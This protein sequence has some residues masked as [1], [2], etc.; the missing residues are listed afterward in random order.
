MNDLSRVWLRCWIVIAASL[1]PQDSRRYLWAAEAMDKP[2]SPQLEQASF[3]LADPQLS[4]DLVACEPAVQSPVAV[5]WDARGRMFVAQMIGYPET[6]GRGRIGRLEDR[7]H[8]GRY[9]VSSVFAEGLDFPTSV[10]AIAGGVLVASA[11]D[12]I[13]FADRDDDGRADYQV[14]LLTGFGVGSQQ[15]R[16]NALHYAI[17]GWT[18]G[19][20]GRCDGEVRRPDQPLEQAVSIRGKDFR[21]RISL[22]DSARGEGSA[23]EP[24]TPAVSEFEAI[25][26]QSQ[27]GQSHD[28]WGRRFLSWNTIPVRQVLFETHETAGIWNALDQAVLDTAPSDDTGRVFPISPAPLQFNT[29]QSNY[30]NAMCGLCLFGGDKLGEAYVG[31]AFVCESL[32]N[33]ITR[34]V[35]TQRGVRFESDRV[36]AERNCEFIASRD[37]WFHPVNLATGPDGALY[38]V[39][40]YRQFVEHPIYVSDKQA[41]ATTDWQNGAAY[42]RIWRVQR[43]SVDRRAWPHLDLAAATGQEL[44]GHLSSPVSTVRLTAQ[45]LLSER[46]DPTHVDH[47]RSALHDSDSALARA[48]ALWTMQVTGRLADDDLL[49]GLN[50]AEPL[51]TCQ[52]LRIIADQK[53]L[54]A[55]VQDRLAA[56]ADSK[57]AEIRFRL[58]LVAPRINAQLRQEVLA[59]LSETD[60]AD[61]RSAVVAG[62]AEQPGNLIDKLLFE[63]DWLSKPTPARLLHLRRLGEQLGLRDPEFVGGFLKRIAERSNERIEPGGLAVICGLTSRMADDNLLHDANTRAGESWRK[64]SPMVIQTVKA[65]LNSGTATVSDQTTMAVE[66]L[67]HVRTPQGR[68]LL[69]D[70][71]RRDVPISI[72]AAALRAATHLGDSAIFSSALARWNLLATGIRTALVTA[73]AQSPAAADSLAVALERK[74]VAISELTPSQRQLL[75]GLDQHRLGKWMRDA[76]AETASDRQRVVD[77]FR[78]ALAMSGDSARGALVYR[79]KCMNCHSLQGAGEQVGPDLSAAGGRHKDTLLV[80]IFDPSRNVE[81]NYVNYVLTTVQGTIAS[82]IIVAETSEAISLRREGQQQLTWRRNEIGSLVSTGKS[83]M[84]DGLE[85]GLSLQQ[86]ADLLEF[87]R[88]PDAT[89]LSESRQP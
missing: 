57:N 22:R 67:G 20:N 83:I 7:D 69:L 79:A 76:I 27:F 45:R 77:R 46:N 81:P 84:P 12:I 78:P 17:D 18:Y 60:D 59:R 51:V 11:P 55:A 36:E 33:L 38:V 65:Y 14:T 15:L 39:D 63:K 10:M 9:E 35:L 49:Q 89:L 6:Q 56:L 3:Q 88:T 87:L 53:S 52:A 68:D 58:A 75:A 23:S 1:V 62:A 74:T 44:V 61:V 34:R 19:A 48:H 5:C 21:F 30:Y 64:L 80:D 29:E 28:S 43:K 47:L 50:D 24:V 85:E 86:A 37:S 32:S 40:F 82:G 25:L 42:G 2:Q 73:A 13:Y 26:G 66:L 54:A 72:Q 71:F 8:D 16:A 41:R 31:N 70:L 4:I